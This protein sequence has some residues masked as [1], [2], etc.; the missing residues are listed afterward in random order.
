MDKKDQNSIVT[1][2][3]SRRV[4]EGCE[5][6]FERLST[7]LTQKAVD[8]KGHLG[9]VMFQPSS[10]DDPEYRIIYKFDSQENLDIW[11]NSSVRLELV[12]KIDSLLKEE[13][14]VS[15]SLGLVTWLTLP[16]KQK[17]KA[18]K[19]YKITIVSWLALYPTITLIFFLFGDIL[20][21]IPFLLRIFIVTAVV[22][23]LMS[24]VLMPRFTKWFSFWLFPNDEKNIR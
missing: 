11:I 13:S 22:M 2:V 5:K 8:F 17:I 21:N 19:K 24:Y 14:K 20:A 7:E 18:P 15:T 12:K 4:K 6:E 16:G 10:T 3:V 1:V 23:V 9:A